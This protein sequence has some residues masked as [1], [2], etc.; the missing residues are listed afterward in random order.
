MFLVHSLKPPKKCYKYEWSDQRRQERMRCQYCEIDRTHD[1]LAGKAC[2]SKPE[3]VCPKGMVREITYQKQCGD[4]ACSKHARTMS[5][6][7]AGLY[8]IEA[9]DHKESAQGVQSGV[10][11]RKNVQ[12]FHSFAINIRFR[13]KNPIKRKVRAKEHP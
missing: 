6:Y 12:V 1:T 13:S 9:R 5:V 7:L 8:E 10:Q 4:D 11:M 3:I 2:R